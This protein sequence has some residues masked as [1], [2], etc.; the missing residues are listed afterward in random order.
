MPTGQADGAG[1]G[2]PGREQAMALD[3]GAAVESVMSVRPVLAEPEMS[4][5]D[6]ARLLV[7]EGIGAAVVRGA[8]HPVGVVSE[9][10][11]VRAL[12]DGA[13]PDVASAADVMSPDLVS[14]APDDPIGQVMEAMAD[15]WIRHV[16]VLRGSEVVGMVSARDLVR[17]FSEPLT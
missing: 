5:R 7:D 9:R 10:D 16:P 1:V 13:D 3:L 17:A 15:N 6:V 12:A 11:V 8:D 2:E 4:L 14:A